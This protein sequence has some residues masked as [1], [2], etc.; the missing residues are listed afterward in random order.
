MK[1]SLKYTD[2][3]CTLCRIKTRGIRNSNKL[4]LWLIN[5]ETCRIFSNKF[6]TW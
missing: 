2:Q 4:K 5:C 6:Q 1:S 3:N